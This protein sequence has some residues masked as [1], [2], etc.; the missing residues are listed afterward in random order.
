MLTALD[1]TSVSIRPS[2]LTLV[3]QVK[4][5]HFQDISPVGKEAGITVVLALAHHSHPVIAVGLTKVLEIILT[6][7]I[8]IH[9]EVVEEVVPPLLLVGTL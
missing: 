4:S 5:A 2:V 1:T 8:I 6:V 7:F 3:I 9:M